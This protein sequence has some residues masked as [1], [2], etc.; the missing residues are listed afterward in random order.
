MTIAMTAISCKLET[1]YVSGCI[2]RLTIAFDQISRD[3]L[4][5]TTIIFII[6][7]IIF[8]IIIVLSSTTEGVQRHLRALHNHISKHLRQ[9][10]LANDQN[11]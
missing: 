1:L 5:Q 7:F 2:K 6:I 10:L 9:S 4:N 3:R 8:I 11:T